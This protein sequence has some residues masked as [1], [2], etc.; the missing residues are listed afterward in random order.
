MLEIKFKIDDMLLGSFI[1]I[2]KNYVSPAIKVLNFFKIKLLDYVSI[3]RINGNTTNYLELFIESI[4]CKDCETKYIGENGS[5]L[6]TRQKEHQ[7][8]TYML[9]KNKRFDFSR[10][11]RPVERG[12]AMGVPAPPGRLLRSTFLL[13]KLIVKKK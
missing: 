7:R 10:T 1:F 9:G 8:S 11:C 3:V 4:P 12:G 2:Y 13:K 6:E 5:S